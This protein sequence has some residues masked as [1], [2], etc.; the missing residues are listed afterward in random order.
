MW[1][2]P[3]KWVGW[4]VGFGRV[5]VKAISGLADDGSLLSPFS[6]PEPRLLSLPLLPFISFSRLWPLR[7]R[8]RTTLRWTPIC[9]TIPTASPQQAPLTDFT[10]LTTAPASSPMDSTTPPCKRISNRLI[11]VGTSSPIDRPDLTITLLHC[12]RSDPKHG[13]V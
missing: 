5:S 2:R 10:A 4:L 9:Q 6:Q 12:Y 8:P 3:A 1:E 11:L 13:D 7:P